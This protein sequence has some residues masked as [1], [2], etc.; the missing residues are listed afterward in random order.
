M[1]GF[2]DEGQ[3]VFWGDCLGEDIE[4]KLE[5]CRDMEDVRIDRDQILE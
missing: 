4:E 2:V 1:V 5:K 3:I